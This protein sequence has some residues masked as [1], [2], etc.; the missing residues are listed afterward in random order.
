MPNFHALTSAVTNFAAFGE[1]FPAMLASMQHL[2]DTGHAACPQEWSDL[3]ALLHELIEDEGWTTGMA[4]WEA[5]V[6]ER[7]VAQYRNLVGI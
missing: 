7:F 4:A 1:A 3:T 5:A 6:P 2:S